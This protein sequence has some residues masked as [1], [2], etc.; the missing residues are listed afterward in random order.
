VSSFSH[1]VEFRQLLPI[2]P[3][4]FRVL[5]DFFCFNKNGFRNAESTGIV[6]AKGLSQ[7]SQDFTQRSPRPLRFHSAGFQNPGIGRTMWG[8]TI[9]NHDSDFFDHP[10]LHRS[11]TRLFQYLTWGH[12]ERAG[13]IRRFPGEPVLF[14]AGNEEACKWPFQSRW[15]SA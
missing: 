7:S 10:A 8:R 3:S 6:E 1:D 2:T 12:G 15:G 4:L 5:P 14:F 11:A 13:S 9:K